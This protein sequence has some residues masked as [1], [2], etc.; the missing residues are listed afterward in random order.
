MG[1]AGDVLDYG[2]DKGFGGYCGANRHVP[3]FEHSNVETLPEASAADYGDEP[4]RSSVYGSRG[5]GED[6][7]GH[8]AKAALAL[9][10]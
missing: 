4:G 8:V 6:V 2:D 9:R 3:P 5:M 1:M 10:K 7:S